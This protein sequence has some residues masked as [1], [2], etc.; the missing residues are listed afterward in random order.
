MTEKNTPSH[1]A[2]YHRNMMIN[3]MQTNYKQ[4]V[5]KK[6]RFKYS[7]AYLYVCQFTDSSAYYLN[8]GTGSLD[9][10]LLGKEN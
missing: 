2:V 7:V 3:T 4:K 8:T 5:F 10:F 9:I 6:K 1:S